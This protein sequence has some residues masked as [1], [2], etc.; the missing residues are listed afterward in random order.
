MA[1]SSPTQRLQRHRFPIFTLLN[2][3]YQI[4]MAYFSNSNNAGFYSPSSAP[5]EFNAYPFPS[6]TPVNDGANV[7]ADDWSTGGQPSYTAG[8]SMS[9]RPEATFGKC[10]CSLLDKRR[11]TRESQILHPRSLP[12][13]TG[14]RRPP[15][16]IGP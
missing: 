11:L 15:A 3:S 7:F 14:S 10:S 12:T 2:S 13:A 9:L 6:Q 1:F 16:I 4:Q 5:S 8:P